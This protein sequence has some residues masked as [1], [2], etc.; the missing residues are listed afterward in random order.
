MPINLILTGLV[1]WGVLVPFQPQAPVF[2]NKT[3]IVARIG[4]NNYKL[5]IADSMSKRG[6]GLS[7][8]KSLPTDQG[9]LFLF[10]QPG[11]YHFVMDG[12][13]FPLDFIWLNDGTV[14]DLKDNVPPLKANQ[15]SINLT[16]KN[17]FDQAIELN[18]GEIEKSGLKI[19]N[20]VTYF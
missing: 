8:R 16:A 5:E 17:K 6:R 9:M 20:R 7:W 4:N 10:D 2:Q 12:M 15:P 1:L 19:G 14:V 11:Q 3:A 13:R 18:A